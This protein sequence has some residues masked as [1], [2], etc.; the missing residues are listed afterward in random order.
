MKKL[1]K[2]ANRWK[3]KEAAGE[4]CIKLNIA[5]LSIATLLIPGY[6]A[7]AWSWSYEINP[8]FSPNV[9]SSTSGPVDYEYKF[10]G[11]SYG[12]VDCVPESG[13]YG[14]TYEYG[15]ISGT[16]VTWHAV[17]ERGHV[18]PFYI[19]WQSPD[20][21]SGLQS[22]DWMTNPTTYSPNS[23]SGCGID[24]A[25]GGFYSEIDGSLNS[26][27]PCGDWTTET[28]SGS[29]WSVVYTYGTPTPWCYYFKSGS[30]DCGNG[31]NAYSDAWGWSAYY[32]IVVHLDTGVSL[33][34]GAIPALPGPGG[35]NI[36]TNPKALV[37]A[38]NSFGTLRNN[39]NGWVGFHFHVGGSPL[40]VTAL[41][42]WIVSGN[43]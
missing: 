31:V 10:E 23:G 39:L 4:T 11:S 33:P 1:M 25:D 5:L 22:V 42:R 35:V 15:T 40:V 28:N 9:P 29:G 41:G 38:V 18:S 43:T 26:S 17:A 3:Y 2:V 8:H 36:C 6:V 19:C 13:V 24:Y 34:L 27:L 7:D 21:C 30:C 20:P 37:S 12:Y 14:E 32:D 16:Q